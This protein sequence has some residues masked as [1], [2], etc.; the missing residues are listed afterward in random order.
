[1]WSRRRVLAG[2]A[3]LV[4]GCAG[5]DT[6]QPETTI[7]ESQSSADGEPAA[8]VYATAPCPNPLVEGRPELD[9]GPESNA[10]T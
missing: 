10:A 7:S 6:G 1:M 3:V 5:D 8:V 4:V 9:L 2:V